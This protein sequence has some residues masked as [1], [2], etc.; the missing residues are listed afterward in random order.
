MA[1]PTRW[2]WVWANSRSWWW[3]GKT[4]T[5]QFRGS[6][7]VEH[8]WETELNWITLNQKQKTLEKTKTLSQRDTCIPMLIA[9]LFTTA[10][11]WKW[12]NFPSTDNWF[13]KIQCIYTVDYYSAIKKEQNT[14]ICNN[15]ERPREY[16]SKWSNSKKTIIIQYHLYMESKNKGIYIQNKNRLGYRKQ[17]YG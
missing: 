8:D 16:H 13:K 14:A 5:W 7:R 11:I 15:M 9:A 12:P 4:G 1:S 6:Q 2:T 17:T 3:T 10:K